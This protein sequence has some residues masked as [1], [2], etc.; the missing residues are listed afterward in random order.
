MFSANSKARRALLFAC[1][2]SAAAAGSWWT[3][4]HLHAPQRAEY[5]L[6][7]ETAQHD[8]DL[9]FKM[10]LKLAEK[11]SGIENALV[12][13]DA[14][15]PGKSIEETAAGLFEQLRIGARRNGRG[16][17]Y[18]YSARENVLRVLVS[19][20]LEGDIPD[21]Y[22]RRLEEAAK[23]Y[24]LSEVPQ[25]F[26]SELIIT[27]NL[28]GM[29][30]KSAADAPSRPRWLSDDFLAGGGGAL[31]SGY[32][33]TLAD[34]Q[35]AIRSLPT[36]DLKQYLPSPDPEVTMERYLSSLAAGI[37]DPRLPLLTEGSRIFRAV[38]PRDDA[39]QKRI[40]EFFRAAAP[41]RLI[42]A[43]D[44]GLA[45]PQPSHSNL[46][47]VLRRGSDKLWY[48]DEPK[49]WTYFHRFEDNVNFFV[50]Y[51]DNPFLAS[52]RA[53]RLPNMERAIY[54]D[55]ARAPA[56]PAYPYSLA[57]EIQAREDKIR[58]EPQNAAAHAALGD[59][60]LFEMNWLTKSIAM[61]EKA[62][63]L[64]PDELAYHWRLM[65]LYLNASRAD[66]S[67]A[68]L[69]YLSDHLPADRQTQDWYRQ[70]RKEYDFGGQ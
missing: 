20:D 9:A 52:L 10:S 36:A 38:V 51:S 48:V 4:R 27:T 60:Y 5:V 39:Q 21:A 35:R 2:A 57:A 33:K 6:I 16:I 63:A 11:K 41:Y 56:A 31:V 66:K 67:L 42:F 61:Y 59:L 37:G 29:G 40:Y 49:A 14:L 65:D 18:L 12:L 28:R 54:G 50:K 70:Y 15:P 46:P 26:I 1:I 32:G 25:D 24:M 7:N 23:T 62:A 43:G 68:E 13:L 47:F 22:C 8:Y 3:W 45:V 17:L 53:L 30:S 19:Y 69:K 34:Y 64:A 58:A 55:H 44:L